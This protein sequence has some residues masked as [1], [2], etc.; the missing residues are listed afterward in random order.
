MF[1][2]IMYAISFD[3]DTDALKNNYGKPSF[4]NAYSE[5]RDFLALRGF[6]NQQGSLY[7]GDSSVTQVSTVLAIVA[8]SRQFPYLKKSI[9]DIRV[10]Q[11]VTQDDLMP[12]IIEGNPN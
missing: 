1:Q 12:A 11:L 5:V 2:T 8:L 9:A 10:L 3:L 6:K 4:N 7:Y